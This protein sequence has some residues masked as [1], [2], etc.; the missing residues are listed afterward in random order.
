M[1]R[2]LILSF[3]ILFSS[4]SAEA[5]LIINEVCS[6][7]DSI[8]FDEFN[9]H[10]DWIELYN[11]GNQPER[12]SE[13][14][15]TETY[16]IPFD[17]QLPNVILNSGE[18]YLILASGRGLE[19]NR[20]HTNFK[21]SKK[22]EAIYLFKNDKS[23]ID[24]I[25]VPRNVPDW[26]YGRIEEG[27]EW[28]FFEV[29]SP[30]QPNIESIQILQTAVPVFSVLEQFQEQP[31]TLEISSQTAGA[32]IHFTTDGSLPDLS[33]PI[34]TGPIEVSKT[35]SIRA[36]AVAPEQVVSA[37]ETN[38]YF[39]SET[40]ELP[41]VALSVDS[42]LLFD[43]D[44]GMLV[45]GPDAEPDF[46]YWGANFWKDIELPVHFEY[47]S[48][49]GEKQ[50]EFGT[51]CK[52]HGGRSS[53]TKPQRS[54]RFTANPKFGIDKFEY[55]FFEDKPEVDVFETIVLRNSSG[56]FNNT[57]FRDGFLSYYMKAEG[58]D[59]DLMGYQ[60][61]NVYLNG[62]YYGVMNLREKSDETFVVSNYGGDLD[63]LD[64]LEEDTLII[65]GDRIEFSEDVNFVRNSDLTDDSVF[66]EVSNR[67]DINSFADYIIAETFLNNTDWGHNNLKLWKA[68]TPESKWRYL[69]FDLDVG[70][71]G[72]PWTDAETEVLILKFNQYDDDENDHIFVFKE[73][74]K[75]LK[76]HNYFINRYCDLLNTTFRPELF[77]DAI[78]EHAEKLAPSL[79]PHYDR[80]NCPYCF[81]FARWDTTFIPRILTYS[82]T[83]APFSRKE[84]QTY[85]E[86][87]NEVLL[88]LD[89][90]PQGAGSI[91]INT[92]EPKEFP[93]NGYYFK[94]V[95]VELTA[96]AKAGFSFKNWEAIQSDINSTSKELSF[97]FESDDEIIAVFE[98]TDSFESSVLEIFPNPAL[99]NLSVEFFIE[100]KDTVQVKVFSVDGKLIQSFEKKAVELG[101]QLFDINI[102]NLVS[103]QYYLQVSNGEVDKN[104]SF[105]KF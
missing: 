100:A 79:E 91:Q 16:D 29:P 77:S 9:D 19:N 73:L 54:L 63:Q 34:Y 94:G 4:Y 93:W 49:E 67:F 47:F 7:N 30:S 75:N 95:P 92:I 27:S 6:S 32:A 62:R 2:H 21:I 96:V 70:M 15:L 26:S 43:K 18:F 71:D 99:E 33:S 64:V 82:E 14:Y 53:R 22:G 81:S 40:T 56:D 102:S 80:W 41:M 89:V 57:H 11:S 103:G 25:L 1:L 39:V 88:N 10:P 48:K 13:Y 97:N 60:P 59:L 87:D 35:T 101:S 51:E 31:F 50:I 23:L 45:F 61:T 52:V 28:G 78:A 5:Q 44:S 24:G 37:I 20:K 55:P 74:L 98:A 86:L 46:P 85:F 90:Q 72:V 76:F 83:K 3:C 42:L 12:L 68:R 65:L 104:I 38:T 58:L 8:Y 84:L 66:E 17:W 69:L 36:F 105:Q